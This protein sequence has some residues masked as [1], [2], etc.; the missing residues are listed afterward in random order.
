MLSSWEKVGIGRQRVRAGPKTVVPN[1]LGRT[2]HHCSHG[3]CSDAD[4]ACGCWA[5]YLPGLTAFSAATQTT[6]SYKESIL[7]PTASNTAAGKSALGR[8]LSNE[9]TAHALNLHSLLR[10]VSRDH[11]LALQTPF[12][13]DIAGPWRDQL[14]TKFR[15]D[16]QTP[17]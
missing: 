10:G 14:C 16:S 8:C 9:P 17:G 3:L 13:G 6:S 7:C 2:L 1:P 11:Q 5:P 12:H 4:Q 15:V